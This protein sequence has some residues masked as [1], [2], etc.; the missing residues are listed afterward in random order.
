MRP[1]KRSGWLPSKAYQRLFIFSFVFFL[2]TAVLAG[3]L[4]EPVRRFVTLP[5]E[6]LAWLA[7]STYL[8]IPRPFLWIGF[9][10]LGYWLA[11]NS[12]QSRAKERTDDRSP[13]PELYAEPKIARLARYVKLSSR[14]FFRHR[15]NHVVTELVVQ[16]LAY[17]QQISPQQARALLS[18][19]QAELPPEVLEYV[20]D[21]L[22]PWP[23]QP[24]RP[25]S[26]LGRLA[27]GKEARLKALAD[28]GQTLDFLENLLEVPHDR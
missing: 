20:K 15:L 13:L 19:D 28:A 6:F 1:A 25:A 16:A 21:G 4:F 7:R 24:L 23:L 12:L 11:L 10:V 26:F 9:L 14:P 27:P 18:K 5:L 22:P 17:R 3:L 8:L 2:L